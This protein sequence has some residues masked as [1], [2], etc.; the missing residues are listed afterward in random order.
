MTTKITFT[1]ARKSARALGWTLRKTEFANEI[2]CYPV[3]AGQDCNE[4][5]F[6]DCPRD[7][8][9]T[10]RHIVDTTRSAF[11]TESPRQARER[12]ATAGAFPLWAVS[13]DNAAQTI[14]D[15]LRLGWF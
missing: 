7:A 6:T 5:Y 4:C 10:V 13:Q 14:D 12:R 3:G 1:Q 9:D 15:A 11:A 8:I 2:A